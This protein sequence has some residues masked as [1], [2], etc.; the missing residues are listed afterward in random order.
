MPLTPR[1]RRVPEITVDFVHA[2]TAEVVYSIAFPVDDLA[3][4]RL[5]RQIRAMAL[6]LEVD[7]VGL[8]AAQSGPAVTCAAYAMT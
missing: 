4:P 5:T 2:T 3:R 6:A 1:I 8:L 7:T